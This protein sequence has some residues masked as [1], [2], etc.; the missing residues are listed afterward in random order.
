MSS[1]RTRIITLNLGSQS[2]ELA[3]FRTQP[4]GGMASEEL[5]GAMLYAKNRVGYR[6]LDRA[7]FGLLPIASR[8]GETVWRINAGI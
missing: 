3:E 4:Q 8:R 5:P 2:I 1:P 6:L 7:L